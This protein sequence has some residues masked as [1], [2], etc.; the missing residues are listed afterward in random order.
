MDREGKIRWEGSGEKDWKEVSGR[1]DQE[2]RIR[3]P[4][5]ERKDP[6]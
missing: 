2:G 3:K 5:S 6:G 4:G 1:K